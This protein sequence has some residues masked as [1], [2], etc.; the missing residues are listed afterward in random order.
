MEGLILAA[1]N[2]CPFSKY[3]PALVSPHP[4]QGIPVRINMGQKA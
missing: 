3:K 4:A 1:R 2:T